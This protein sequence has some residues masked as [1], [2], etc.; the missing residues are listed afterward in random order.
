MV[1]LFTIE[2]GIRRKKSMYFY[3]FW[4]SLQHNCVINI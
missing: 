4:L 3:S 2:T 1:V